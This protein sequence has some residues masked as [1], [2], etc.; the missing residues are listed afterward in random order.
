MKH[1]FGY[2]LPPGVSV[3]DIEDAQGEG[4]VLVDFALADLKL[5]IE[6]GLRRLK[7]A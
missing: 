7:A 1:Q 6:G 3:N 4:S 2:D 5:W